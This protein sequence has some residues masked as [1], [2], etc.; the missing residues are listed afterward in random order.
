LQVRSI[1]I[2]HED[3]NYREFAYM[4]G[5]ALRAE[6]KAAGVSAE[7]ISS[8]LRRALDVMKERGPDGNGVALGPGWGLGH[9]RL[10]IIDIAAG[11]QPWKSPDGRAMVYNG[12][13]FNYLQ[14]NEELRRAGHE[15]RTRCDTETVFEA[16]LEWGER[17]VEKFNGFFAFAIVDPVAGRIFAARDRLGVKPLHYRLTADGLS[18]ASSVAA[19]AA[20]AGVPGRE[21]DIEALSHYLTTG[22][23]TFGSKTLAAGISALPPAHVLSVGLDGSSFRTARY[24]SRPILSP[25]EKAASAPTLEKAVAETRAL[26][27]DAVGIRLMSDVPLGSFLSGGLDSSIIALCAARRLGASAPLPFYCAGSDEESMNE[28]HYAKLMADSLGR[29]V[30]MI[31]LDANG[32]LADWGFLC[33]KKGL[34]LS[35][36]NEVSIYHLSRALGR[37]CKVA[38]TGEGADELFGGYVAAQYSALDLERSLLGGDDFESSPLG[39]ALTFSEG[40]CRFLN[41]TD[42][43]LSTVRWL[44]YAL[45]AS[46]FK[47]EAWDALEEDSPVFAFY[48]DFFERHAKCG[49]FDRRMHL[50]AEFNLESLLHRIDNS[51]MCASVEARVPFTDFRLAEFAFRMPDHYKIAPKDPL[52]VAKIAATSAQELAAKGMLESK[53]LPRRAFRSEIPDEIVERPKKSFPVPLARWFKSDIAGAVFEMCMESPL[54]RDF[55]RRD[56]LAETLKSASG[57]TLW[58]IANVCKWSDA[59]G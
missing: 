55:F 48:E 47:P 5:I 20:C 34:P 14:I 23:V 37:K 39:V 2:P 21:T 10:A 11:A 57:E 3:G 15:I 6:F 59:A 8:G 27:D 25:E 54:A 58:A 52:L 28:F 45:K 35:T 56:V 43:F 19:V 44:P 1:Y 18:L 31:R 50:F 40:R 46:L 7:R 41:D 51:S 22:R 38:L 26:L 49:F 9:T 29:D 4:C 36:P 30:E 33:A 12:E 42:H 13:I 32:F 16:Y 24:W 17:C 53:V